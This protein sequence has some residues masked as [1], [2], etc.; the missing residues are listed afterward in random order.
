MRWT[1]ISQPTGSKAAGSAVFVTA[2]NAKHLTKLIC[3]I[4]F[5]ALSCGLAQQFSVDWHKIAGGGGISTGG[6]FQVRGT[7]GQHDAGATS[8]GGSY[9]L[10][11]GFWAAEALQTSGAPVLTITLTA[12]NTAMIYWSSPSTGFSLQVNSSLSATNWI[13]PSERVQDNGAIKFI[14]VNLPSGNHFYRLNY[15]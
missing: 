7:I 3:F 8:S 11:G 10:T 14:I 4:S 1:S 13:T 6:V 5:M 15:P 9:S 12:T 2:R